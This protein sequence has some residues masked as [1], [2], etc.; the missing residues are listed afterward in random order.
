MFDCFLI[1][2]TLKNRK[3]WCKS[4]EFREEKKP[5]VETLTKKLQYDEPLLVGD[6]QYAIS[7]NGT[8]KIINTDDEDSELILPMNKIESNKMEKILGELKE[9]M[10]IMKEKMVEQEKEINKL[11]HQR[12]MAEEKQEEAI[13]ESVGNKEEEI[14]EKE[15]DLKRSKKKQE[16]IKLKNLEDKLTKRIDEVQ[17]QASQRLLNL[18]KKVNKNMEEMESRIRET[19]NNLDA[20]V[21]ACSECFKKE[22]FYMALLFTE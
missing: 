2:E 8:L 22:E 16:D 6:W 17:S 21:K 19:Q 5:F 20:I 18:E 14:E 4:R 12:V 7:R 1:P 15:H 10:E 13:E 11:K 9:E 3:K